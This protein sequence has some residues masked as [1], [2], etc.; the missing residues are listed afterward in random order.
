MAGIKDAMSDI[1]NKLATL[2]V[3]NNDS[4]ST[5]PYVRVW[6]NQL[7]LDR[8]GQVE[9]FPKP[10][11]FL[12]VVTPVQYEII[13]QGYRDADVN[14][15]IH[16]IHEY[17]ND[18]DG[19]TFEQDLAVFDLRDQLIALLTYFTP[20]GCGP[21]VSVAEEQDFDHDNLYHFVVDFL[22]NFTDAKGSR[23]DT[24]RNYYTE[25]TPPTSLNVQVT[26]EQ[27]GSAVQHN[28]LIPQRK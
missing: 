5:Y 19:V 7:K 1:L 10:A 26:P 27:G 24:G 4:T 11:L 18:G 21:L 20:A 8:Q 15:R 28:F 2:S 13:G 22:C 23:L 9:S 6:N 12:E 16:I 25:S 3:V 14:F 17:Y